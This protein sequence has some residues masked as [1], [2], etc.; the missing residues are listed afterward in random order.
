MVSK[1]TME[2]MLLTETKSVTF[3]CDTKL[4]DSIQKEADVNFEGNFSLQ[5][6]KILKEW[7][8]KN[9]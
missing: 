7:T 4:Y 5:L 3:L 8:E 2:Q 6:R 1:Q 9:G